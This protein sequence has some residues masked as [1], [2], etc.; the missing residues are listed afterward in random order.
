MVVIELV[1]VRFVFGGS[2]HQDRNIARRRR[3]EEDEVDRSA[4]SGR[5]MCEVR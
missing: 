1:E 3:R 5:G 4:T 2:N